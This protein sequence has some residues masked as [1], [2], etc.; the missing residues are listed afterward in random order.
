MTTGLTLYSQISSKVADIRE[1]SLAVARMA[2]LLL[3]TVTN[4]SATG[5]MD[6]S[7]DEYNAITFAEAGEDDDTSPQEFDKDALASLSPKI[8]RAR[9]DITDA[10]AET[11][12][13]SEIANASLEFGGAAAKHVD[14]AIA[15]LFSSADGGTI[16][17]GASSTI[18]WKYVTS[19]YAIVSN[20]DI[21]AGAPVYCALHPFQWAVLLAANS[22]AAATVGVAPAFQDRLVAAP[23]YFTVPQF[24]GITFVITNSIAISGTA[25]YGCMYVPQA[26]AVDTRKRFNIRPQRDESRELTELNASMWYVAGV[27]RPAFAVALYTLAATPDGS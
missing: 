15:G 24:Q 5:M 14:S 9:V 16:G 23:N 10:R 4:M 2:N 3:P 20:A 12:Y 19:A 22:I 25:A 21:P 1:D 17:S 13:D 27:W 7:V 11:D 26:F 8:Y 18:T 6:R